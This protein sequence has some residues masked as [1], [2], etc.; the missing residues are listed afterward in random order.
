MQVNSRFVPRAS[1]L[2]PMRVLTAAAPAQSPIAGKWHG[3]VSIGGAM[4]SDNT[5]STT[6]AANAN[7][8]H[9]TT[10]DRI[11]LYALGN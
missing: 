5:R 1:V 8:V 3:G 4:A 2:A 11:R 10:A 7:A 6:F 9:A